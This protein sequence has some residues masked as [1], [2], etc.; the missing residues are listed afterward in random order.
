MKDL[1]I[2]PKVTRNFNKRLSKGFEHKH[3]TT[4]NICILVDNI[5]IEGK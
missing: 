4:M 3:N 5:L 1:K 2:P